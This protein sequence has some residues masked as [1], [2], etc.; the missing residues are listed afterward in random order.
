V[1]ALILSVGLHLLALGVTL[2]L[3]A[4]SR[5][6]P[7]AAPQ[8]TSID[9]CQR[10]A[11]TAPDDR[12]AWRCLYLYARHNGAWDDVEARLLR[13]LD[14]DPSL[15]HARLNLGHIYSDQGDP[16]A[17]PT[18]EAA[19][20]GYVRDGDVTGQVQARIALANFQAHHDA[21]ADQVR[22]GLWKAAEVADSS[23]DPM[24]QATVAVQ[25]ARFLWRTGDDYVEAWRL[26]KSAES[27]A[28]PDGP[29]QLRVL[30]L[31]VLAGLS[32]ATGRFDEALT[33]SRRLAE[34][35]ASN[36]DRYVEATARL[37]LA[38]LASAHPELVAPQRALTESAAALTA[39]R[40][41]D[42]PYAIA[43]A[44]CVR[45]RA[46]DIAGEPGSQALWQ[47][48]ADEFGALGEPLSQTLGVLGL[49]GADSATDPDRAVRLA[50]EAVAEAQRVGH[51]DAEIDARFAEAV[52]RWEAQGPA[53]GQA[54]FEAHLTALETLR[55]RQ[56]DA[57]TR[58]LVASAQAIGRYHL[59][60]R[61]A[62]LGPD[63]VGDA[64]AVIESLRARELLDRMD[65][66][67]DEDAAP[68]SLAE[69]QAALAPGEALLSFQ[70]PPWQDTLPAI[71][72]EPW[73]LL[74][75]AD[76]VQVL[77]LPS[78]AELR[79]AVRSLAG[80]VPQD[81]EGAAPHVVPLWDSLIARALDAAGP[82]L[83]RLVL[84]PDGPLHA[85]PFTA[86]RAS[87]DAPPLGELLALSRA[88]SATT[89]LG[90]LR[91]HAAPAPGPALV[92]ADPT[93]S[94]DLPALPA[95][96]VEARHFATLLGDQARIFVGEQATE[97]LLSSLEAPPRLL[98]LAAH[99]QVDGGPSDRH[100]VVL[101]PGPGDIDGMLQ[102]D[103]IATLPLEGSVVVLSACRSADGEVL[104]LDGVRGLAR[105]FLVAGADTVV[106]S[107]WAV[108]DDAAARFMRAFSE[109]LTGGQ[110]VDQA[111]RQAR[112]DLRAR[113]EPAVGWAGFV[114][115][116][117]GEARP[118]PDAV[119]AGSQSRSFGL[120][121]GTA[122]GFA[123][124]AAFMVWR[125]RGADPTRTEQG[126]RH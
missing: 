50:T 79:V 81:V 112:E 59:A 124:L 52:L 84:I 122:L 73:A 113:G 37:N 92:L 96:R 106:G 10:A 34:L 67:V 109:G 120:G 89:W 111:L 28:F 39:A 20:E 33:A 47:R 36:G 119:R 98:H 35:T 70:L 23:G 3:G 88:P 78:R 99:A 29:Y 19:L 8:A 21:T 115:I 97:A 63:H 45:A 118:W 26:V 68:A 110:T 16:R 117:N 15:H 24:L 62:H 105:A 14:Q 123:G 46:L 102:P 91:R 56:P 57:E 30:V 5:P 77:P 95:A 25:Q 18:Y 107:L 32:E 85:L 101:A 40:A 31:H 108:P 1:R 38:A 6:A 125:R 55:R 11:D 93:P 87:P 121:L 7:A 42:N 72:A 54:A 64:L 27:Y 51:Q 22:D 83:H 75:T 61:L 100:A 60:S 58:A 53:A 48:C 82:D 90:L 104:D 49:A 4:W 9:A 94:A 65:G 71:Q 114:A 74:L 69:L 41:V 80:L 43:G 2:R 13:A 116:G 17:I 103:E 12:D 66:G 44:A 86:L 126:H 76:R